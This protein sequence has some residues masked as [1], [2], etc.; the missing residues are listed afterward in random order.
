MYSSF[1]RGSS[2]IIYVVV[3]SKD[4]TKAVELAN[5]ISKLVYEAL[6][7]FESKELDEVKIFLK[8]ERFIF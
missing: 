4:E 8:K 7:S 6:T 3:I 2:E 1:A 5:F